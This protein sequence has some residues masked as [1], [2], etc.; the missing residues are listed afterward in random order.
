MAGLLLQTSQCALGVCVDRLRDG[1]PRK[2]P[3]GTPVLVETAKGKQRT[4]LVGRVSMDMI[5]IDVTDL[6]VDV[7]ASI[8]LWGDGLPADDIARHCQ[9]IAYELFCQLTARVPRIT[10]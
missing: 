6:Q 4:T 7:G 10:S 1:Y 9:T 5:T 2:A 8:V 3:T